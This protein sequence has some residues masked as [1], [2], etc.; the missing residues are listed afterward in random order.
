M[1]EKAQNHDDV[2]NIIKATLGESALGPLKLLPGTW[3]NTKSL[4][5]H[6]WNMIAVP[7]NEGK[8]HYRLLLNQYNEK[9]QFNL[10]DK[11][12]PNRGLP[13]LGSNVDGDQ[14]LAALDYE[15]TV[16]KIAEDDASTYVTDPNAH[17]LS[18]LQ[19][20]TNTVIHH[21]VGLWL[22]MKSH[23]TASLD[24]ARLSTVPHSDSVLAQGHST[25]DRSSSDIPDISGLPQHVD[26]DLS[27]PNL[28]PYRFFHENP[29][30]NV[31]DPTLPNEL[32]KATNSDVTIVNTT[33]IEVNTN[34]E[35]GGI[36][37]IPFILKQANVAQMNFTLWIHELAEKDSQGQ[38][39]LRLQYSQQVMLDFFPSKDDPSTLIR[40]PH[41]SINTLEKVDTG[42]D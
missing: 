17:K 10:V 3:E 4:K 20:E 9:L 27:S 15:Q 5:G 22:H 23:D 35:S 13:L 37:N 2:R 36:V 29:F 26:Q 33:R 18:G 38:P 8:F 21:E 34:V 1:T 14:Y 25:K 41:V 42:K 40:W 11:N 28:D 12:V 7:F 16:T 6:G 30:K 31:F 24:I 39:R 19:G 32:L